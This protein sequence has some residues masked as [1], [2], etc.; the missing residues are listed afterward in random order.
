MGLKLEFEPAGA[1]T[2]RVAR[3][4]GGINVYM[5]YLYTIHIY[6]WGEGRNVV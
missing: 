5:V 4:G 1:T 6:I 3:P 2:Q